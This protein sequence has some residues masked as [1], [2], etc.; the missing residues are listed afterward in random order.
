MLDD[1]INEINQQDNTTRHKPNH[2]KMK[3][4][5]PHSSIPTGICPVEREWLTATTYD[6]AGVAITITI[7][8]RGVRTQI[9][10]M[11]S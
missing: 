4:K 1:V 8:D 7:G 10:F 6:Q 11:L 2:L 5:D 3:P 9:I